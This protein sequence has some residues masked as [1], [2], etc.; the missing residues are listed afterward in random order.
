[1]SGSIPVE[2]G[3]LSNLERAVSLQKSVEWSDPILGIGQSDPT[4]AALWLSQNALSGSIPVELGNLSNLRV[5]SLGSNALSGS[6]PAE[7]GN[8]TN[9]RGRCTSW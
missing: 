5:L 6:I 3:N 4:L 1:M 2:L 9:L 8:L 7:L